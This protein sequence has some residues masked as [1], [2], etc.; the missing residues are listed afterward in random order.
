MVSL[1]GGLRGAIREPLVWLDL[2]MLGFECRLYGRRGVSVPGV[3]SAARGA[4]DL[5]GESYF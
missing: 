2:E 3:S 5:V 1:G 4:E